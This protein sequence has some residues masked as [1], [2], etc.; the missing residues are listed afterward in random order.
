MTS[1]AIRAG[2][3]SGIHDPR[4]ARVRPIGGDDRHAI[5]DLLDSL[6]EPRPRTRY[7]AAELAPRADQL[8]ECP[9]D[10]GVVAIVGTGAGTHLVGFAAWCPTDDPVCSRA[11]LAV[12]DGWRMTEVPARMLAA[13]ARDAR[14]EGVRCFTLEVVPSNAVLRAAARALGLREHRAGV[15]VVIELGD[16]GADGAP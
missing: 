14:R 16:D 12:A 3:E 11:V 13:V 6:S 9:A 1:A 10:R 4:E 8:H 7:H 2:R 5:A 15:H